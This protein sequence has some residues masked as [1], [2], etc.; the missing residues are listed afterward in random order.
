MRALRKAKGL[1]EYHASHPFD[2]L[3]WHRRPFTV[4]F[5]SAEGAGRFLERHLAWGYLGRLLPPN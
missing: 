4:Q 5:T 1:D 2:L 3:Y